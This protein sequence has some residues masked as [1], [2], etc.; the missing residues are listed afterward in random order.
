MSAPAFRTVDQ[1]TGERRPSKFFEALAAADDQAAELERLRAENAEL[2]STPRFRQANAAI[3]ALIAD[4]N[5]EHPR[6]EL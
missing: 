3:D 1:L 2:L 6:T 4:F 5:R